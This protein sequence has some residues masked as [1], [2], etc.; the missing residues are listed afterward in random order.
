M[1]YRTSRPTEYFLVENRTRMGLDR[2]LDASGLAVYHCD[3]LGS[4]EWQ[5]GTAA[6]HY[7]CALLQ[8]D[9]R[10]DLEQDV[11]RGDGDDLYGAIQGVALS[12]SSSPNSREWDGRDSGLVIADI[13]AQGE[14]ITF[15]AGASTPADVVVADS[16]SPM[17]RIPDNRADGLSSTITFT[18]SGTVAR[19]KVS[20][21]I[22]HTYIG[23]LRITLASPA[24]RRTVL[25]PQLGGSADNLVVSYDL[26]VP[27]VL[28]SMVGQP[29][30]GVWT[31]N[32]RGPGAHRRGHVAQMGD[33]TALVA[34]NPGPRCRHWRRAICRL[35]HVSRKWEPVSGEMREPERSRRALGATD[36]E[37]RSIREA[38]CRT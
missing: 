13:S 10:R 8:A 9:G 17:L 7:Q 16:A 30:K 12:A 4:N 2:G 22:E 1:K 23:D 35:A 5:Q 34:G 11:N 15:R 36:R 24:G 21:D 18:K 33:R 38:H 25:H 19:I 29:I 26:A 32:C 28:D 20:I 31:L 3:T 14:I 27:G 37:S 6:K